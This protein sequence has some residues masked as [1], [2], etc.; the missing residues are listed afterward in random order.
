MMG[1]S[2]IRQNKYKSTNWGQIDATSNRE[3]QISKMNYLILR[4]V[5]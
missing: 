4:K 5:I 1:K 3:N 2:N